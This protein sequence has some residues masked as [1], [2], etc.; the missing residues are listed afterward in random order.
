MANRR[1]TL[2]R[3]I[4]RKT[5]MQYFNEKG[6]YTKVLE[7]D[8]IDLYILK[9]NKETHHIIDIDKRNLKEIKI[10]SHVI[11]LLN[12]YDNLFYWVFDKY[13]IEAYCID[14]NNIEDFTINKDEVKKYVIRDL[15]RPDTV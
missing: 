10:S 6:Y 1:Y 7:N 12:E 15:T 13:I 11:D 14:I 5:L 2:E 4:A 8:E 3:D 9:N